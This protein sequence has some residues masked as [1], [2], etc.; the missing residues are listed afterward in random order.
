MRI[1]ILK[2]CGPTLVVCGVIGFFYV[3]FGGAD[4][5]PKDTLITVMFILGGIYFTWLGNNP[6]KIKKI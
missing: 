2:I 5:Q 4:V 6:D 3:L 1:K